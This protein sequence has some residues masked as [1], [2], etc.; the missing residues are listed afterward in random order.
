MGISRFSILLINK[1]IDRS[2]KTN[3]II[4]FFAQVR[5]PPSFPGL[6]VG[7]AN[8]HILAPQND[9]CKLFETIVMLSIMH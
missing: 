9:K 6:K 8:A 5:A 2:N 4:G 3:D 1:L 7:A